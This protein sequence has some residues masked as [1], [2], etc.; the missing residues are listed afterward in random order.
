MIREEFFD[1][2]DRVAVVTDATGVLGKKPAIGRGVPSS[3]TRKRT[4]CGA[5]AEAPK[6]DKNI[7]ME[8]WRLPVGKIGSQRGTAEF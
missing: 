7:A 4:N 8:F 6:P 5:A 1:L 2:P 3:L